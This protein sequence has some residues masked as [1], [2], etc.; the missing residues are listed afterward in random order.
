M[1]TVQRVAHAPRTADPLAEAC[2][3]HHEITTEFRCPACGTALDI[4]IGLDVYVVPDLPAPAG[5]LHVV[6]VDGKERHRCHT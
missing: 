4:A 3:R 1:Q 2:M 5:Q 6:V